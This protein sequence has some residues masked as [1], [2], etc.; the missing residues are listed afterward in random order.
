MKFKSNYHLLCELKN[1]IYFS[2]FLNSFDDKCH[3]YEWFANVCISFGVSSYGKVQMISGDAKNL[4]KS[5]FNLNNLTLNEGSSEGISDIKFLKNDLLYCFSVKYFENNDYKKKVAKDYDI[6]NIIAGYDGK[7]NLGKQIVVGII[8]ENKNTVLQKIKKLHNKDNKKEIFSQVAKNIFGIED[9]SKWFLRLKNLLE[10]LNYEQ[11]QI[12]DFLS[13]DLHI[14][15]PYLHQYVAVESIQ[16]LFKKYKEVILNAICRCGKTYIAGY[17]IDKY[18]YKKVLWITPRPTST[19]ESCAEMLDSYFNFIKYSKG[20]KCYKNDKDEIEIDKSLEHI[21]MIV[22]RQL[23]FDHHKNI[24]YSFFDLIILDESHLICSPNSYKELEK[25]TKSNTRILHMTATSHRVERF[26]NIPE[27]RIIRYNITHIMNYQEG[28]IYNFGNKKIVDEYKKCYGKENDNILDYYNKLPKLNLYYCPIFDE[29]RDLYDEFGGFSWKKLFAMKKNK[30]LHCS[31]IISIFNKFFG[32]TENSDKNI[33]QNIE[34]ETDNLKIQNNISIVFLPFG[35]GLPVKNIITN[36]IVILENMDTIKEDYS[37]CGYYS[38]NSE[39]PK[40]IVEDIENKRKICNK[41]LIVLVGGMLE[42]GCSIKYA[43]NV[44]MFNDFKSPDSYIQKISRCLTE[45]IEDGKIL[46]TQG[47]VI[48]CNPNRILY[49]TLNF[50][51][52]SNNIHKKIDG[53]ILKLI[54]R[55]RMIRIVKKNMDITPMSLDN[56]EQIY[57]NINNIDITEIELFDFKDL[58][59]LD[60]EQLKNFEIKTQDSKEIVMEMKDKDDNNKVRD[61]DVYREQKKSK[62]DNEMEKKVIENLIII[63]NIKEGNKNLFNYLCVSLL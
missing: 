49:N 4:K 27:E 16:S 26:R 40:K 51:K 39:L 42:L 29:E 12:L 63:N 54:L 7:N 45:N 6:H 14:M 35:H 24:D 22:S 17:L 11:T 30:F 41:K 33:L 9:I 21:F 34:L 43:D 19:K 44:F 36:L 61:Y 18:D 20:K 10:K 62:K 60:Y 38:D 55:K 15:T 5:I 2:D 48:D 52:T 58:S 32:Y 3:L 23:L 53:E 13:K 59:K 1:Y 57:E 25:M 8:C 56:L 50:F 31:S 28:N 46:K 47:N 37:I